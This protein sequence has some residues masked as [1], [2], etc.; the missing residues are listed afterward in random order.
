[1]NPA[2]RARAYLAKLPSAV[3]GRG[4]HAD[5]FK[6][7]CRLVEFGLPWEAA[8]PLFM[9]WNG[10]HCQPPWHERELHHKLADAY[11]HTQPDPHFAQRNAVAVPWRPAVPPPKRPVQSAAVT[12][13]PLA[14]GRPKLPPLTAGTPDQHAALAALR[15]L[16]REGIA[17]A[18]ARG[19][20]RFGEFQGRAAWFITDS[21]GRAATARRLDG[22]PWATD[23]KAWTLR[24]SHGSWPVGSLEASPFPV[25]ALVEGG[26]DLLAAHHFIVTAGRVDDVAAVALLSGNMSIHPDAAPTFAGKRVRVLAQS[27]MKGR[28]AGI[29]WAFQVEAAGGSADSLAAAEVHPTAKD[30]NDLAR[31]DPSNLATLTTI[32][33]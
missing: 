24:H 32:F 31:I 12:P 7:A 2:T 15:G 4:G 6:A 19:L 18:A 8:W 33:P 30:L 21:T 3:A 27:D 14:N 23:V 5:T 25:I 13:R 29:R 11:R 22:Q 9:E 28:A 16:S 10:T 17:L 1:M 26:P 20:V